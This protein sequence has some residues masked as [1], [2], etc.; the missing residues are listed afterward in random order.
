MRRI[1]KLLLIILF[2]GSIFL[3]TGCKKEEPVEEP[4]DTKEKVSVIKLNKEQYID[5]LKEIKIDGT[6]DTVKITKKVKWEVPE[7]ADG[8]TTVSFTI[9]VY[10]TITVDGVKYD[11]I[12]QLNGFNDDTLDLNP[13]YDFSIFNLTK[14]GDIS[15]Y[16][17]LK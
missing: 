17:S 1:F 11:G 4:I 10:Y 7:E 14:D 15:V 13:I 5:Q 16:I 6:N 9:P 12:F 2:I 8:N 3:T